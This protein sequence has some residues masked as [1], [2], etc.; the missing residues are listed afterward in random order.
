MLGYT[1]SRLH[2][3]A[4]G[5]AEVSVLNA[6]P[7]RTLHTLTDNTHI[8]ISLHKIILLLLWHLKKYTELV[9]AEKSAEGARRYRGQ[10]AV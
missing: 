3:D 5:N 7:I 9:V 2:G 10:W 1:A 6:H 4:L 8:H